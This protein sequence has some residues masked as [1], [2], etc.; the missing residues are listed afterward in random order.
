MEKM[1]RKT[2]TKR[3][4]PF[5]KTLLITMLATV[6][7][8]AGGVTVAYGE[9]SGAP[10]NEKK[11]I[12]NGDGTYTIAL[13]VTGAAES[14]THTEATK[15]NVILVL[16]TSSSMVNN[17]ASPGVTRLAAEQD[18]LTKT[19]GI[20]DKLLSQNVPGDSVKS[21]IIEVAIVNFG[22]ASH[23]PQTWTTD[24][25]LLKRTINGLSTDSGTNWEAALRDAQALANAK[26]TAQPNEEVYIIFMT[27]GEPTCHYG[28]TTVYW[29]SDALIDEQW[30]YA[31][32]YARAL[33][34]PGDH[35]FY[36][37]FTWGAANR[38]HYLSSLV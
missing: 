16:D 15:A 13:N 10:A 21:D 22:N 8:V 9:I 33:V 17:N 30:D 34:D 27:D 5:I 1:R 35:T 20:I 7:L 31:N 37:L 19:D 24:G 36:A 3:K 32:D 12:D 29:Q 14:S 28:D 25:S 23:V 26:K 38:A 2:Q 11:L 4:T 6:A 18:A